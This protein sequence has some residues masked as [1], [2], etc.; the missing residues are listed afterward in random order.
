MQC[1]VLRRWLACVQHFRFQSSDPRWRT[2]SKEGWKFGKMFYKPQSAKESNPVNI[3]YITIY[4]I[5][6]LGPRYMGIDEGYS[7]CNHRNQCKIGTSPKGR[8]IDVFF[9]KIWQT[10]WVWLGHVPKHG[11][12][13]KRYKKNGIKVASLGHRAWVFP[14]LCLRHPPQCLQASSSTPAL[15]N[16]K[17]KGY[18]MIRMLF[19]KCLIQL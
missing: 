13:I 3:H 4:F 11:G 12:T 1:L 7:S 18:Q 2:G 6:F 16:A 8:H 14:F 5:Q 15:V 19:C 17:A 10:D 9:T